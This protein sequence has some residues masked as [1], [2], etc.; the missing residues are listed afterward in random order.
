MKRLKSVKIVGIISVFFCLV[1][2]SDAF[3]NPRMFAAAQD[4]FQAYRVD[5]SSVQME[6]VQRNQSEVFVLHVKAR[7]N[8]FDM[9]LMLGFMAAG[10]A[11][12]KSHN[13]NVTGVRVIVEVPYKETLF[14][15]ASST[16]EHVK[17]LVNGETKPEEFM[18][19][20]VIFT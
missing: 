16:I 20:F 9:A 1:F 13:T 12:E 6:I 18:R 11:V 3:A 4:V 10:T 14:V 8:N 7:R 2:A 15:E 19:K 17:K 5:V